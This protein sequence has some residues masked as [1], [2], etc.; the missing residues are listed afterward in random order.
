M[1]SVINI[2]FPLISSLCEGAFGLSVGCS[3]ADFY[4]SAL[5]NFSVCPVAEP[6]LL[7]SVID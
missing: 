6:P 3:N 1:V 2:T 5:R 4:S 7:V